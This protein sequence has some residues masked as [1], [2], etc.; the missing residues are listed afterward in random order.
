VVKRGGGAFFVVK[1]TVLKLLADDIAGYTEDK[2][3]GIKKTVKNMKDK[4]KKYLKNGD[5]APQ[6]SSTDRY[7]VGS[8]N[9]ADLSGAERRILMIIGESTA[10]ILIQ[11]HPKIQWD[12][13]EIEELDRLG[14]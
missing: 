10:R 11:G 7:K 5:S 6:K 12:P 3:L 13:Q 8:Q 14:S 1:K 9:R 4:V 2:K